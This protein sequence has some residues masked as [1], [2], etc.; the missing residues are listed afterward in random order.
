LVLTF[1]SY[2]NP[3]AAINRP[4]PLGGTLI[5]DRGLGVGRIKPPV[6]QSYPNYDH[7][8]ENTSESWM[9]LC[10]TFRNSIQVG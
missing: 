4:R 1:L 2:I 8:P 9:R 7:R 6:S 10:H 5:S 3:A